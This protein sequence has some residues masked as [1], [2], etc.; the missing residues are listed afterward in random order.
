VNFSATVWAAEA[1]GSVTFIE[2]TTGHVCSPS[3][4]KSLD[5]TRKPAWATRPGDSVNFDGGML[6][7]VPSPVVRTVATMGPGAVPGTPPMSEIP[8]RPMRVHVEDETFTIPTP[9]K[10]CP[11]VP[12]AFIATSVSW[13]A[14]HGVGEGGWV[15]VVVVDEVLE[16]VVVAGRVVEVVV[17]VEVEVDVEVVAGIDVVEAGVAAFEQAATEAARPSIIA[18]RLQIAILDLRMS[19]LALTAARQT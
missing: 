19:L 17:E 2:V 8:G 9:L 18:D 12:F 1:P 11:A 7:T 15:A 16:D 5:C 4:G 14:V 3:E 6:K 10:I 13:L